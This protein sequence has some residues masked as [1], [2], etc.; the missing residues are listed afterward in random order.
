MTIRVIIADD[1]ALVRAGLKMILDVEDG[2]QVVAEVGDGLSVVRA[3]ATTAADVILMDIR[4]PGIDGIE[5]TRRI[6][7]A[8]PT[9]GRGGVVLPDTHE[10]ADAPGVLVLTT[11]DLD[12]YV[13]EALRAG[14]AGFL[15][16][17]TSPELL[18]EAVRAVAA[19]EGLIAPS[20]T[21]KL[22]E[23]FVRAAPAPA[24]P[25]AALASLTPREREVLDLMVAGRSNPEIAQSLVLSEATVKTHVGRVLMKL[26]L[27][28]R[29]Q[30]VIYAY[31]HG[32]VQ[33]S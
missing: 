16:K 11:Y 9:G 1:Q 2:I 23:E 14:A 13:F 32:L 12:E 6:V 24:K 7:G 10:T 20:V 15:L 4:M 31:E 27:R 18:V 26:G 22:I 17:H 28:D 3:A 19:G 5:A 30:A 33:R 29:V 25:S 21:R 8:S